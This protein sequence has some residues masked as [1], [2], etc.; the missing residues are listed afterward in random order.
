MLEI[1]IFVF[2]GFFAG[3]LIAYVC[4]GAEKRLRDAEKEEV[5]I[6]KNRGAV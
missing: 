5:K 6:D 2:I 3:Y 1:A 4:E